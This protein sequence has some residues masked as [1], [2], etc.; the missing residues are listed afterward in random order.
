MH[1]PR[2]R[3]VLDQLAA[4]QPGPAV[5]GSTVHSH[6]LEGNESPD[7]PPPGVVEAVTA[8]TATANRYPDYHGT[9]LIR[10]LARLYDVSPERIALGAGSVALLQALFQA[11]AEP[12]AEVV[13]A[14][15]S[16]ELYPVLA[17]LAGVRTRRVPLRDE[18]HDLSA[19]ADQVNSRTRLVIVCNPNNPTGT[20]ACSAE[21]ED[22]L[23][24]V[25]SDCLVALDEAYRE[26]VRDPGSPDG[27]T[28]CRDRPNVVLLR[29]FS[30]AYGIAGLR[31]GYLI[32]DPYVVSRLR[33]ACLP[34]SVSTVAQA[35]AT[36]A[37]RA[38]DVV[39]ERVDAIVAER[40]RMRA[41]LLDAGWV[42]P[43]SETNFLWLPLDGRSTAFGRWCDDRGIG[44]RVFPDEGVRAS[45]GSRESNDALLAAAAAWRVSSIGRPPRTRM[46][47]DSACSS[48]RGHA[49]ARQAG[50][51]HIPERT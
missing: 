27:L 23:D 12:G 25:P 8:A 40:I 45:V 51:Q 44:V 15:R 20:V 43:P 36:A 19:M 35:A 32:G 9:E 1:R 21:F 48:L 11:V 37:L 2:V 16:F 38:R 46:A 14:W 18:V 33:T 30:K 49:S 3:S 4:Y 41:A 17:D 28:L 50:D 42:V 39:R 6:L 13:H 29:T 26:Y 10:E 22:F 34:F 47:A 5:R 7:D 31:A 24:R